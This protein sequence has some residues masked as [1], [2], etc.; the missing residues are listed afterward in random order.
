M[1][2]KIL[3]R[4]AAL[5]FVFVVIAAFVA[6][7]ISGSEAAVSAACGGLCVAIPNSLVVFTLVV[8][9]SSGRSGAMT[10]LVCEFLKMACTC[11]LFVLVAKLYPELVWPAMI[12][13]VIAAVCS[14][15]ALI[16]V[17]H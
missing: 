16:F 10:V 12:F 6:W 8:G 3:V 17:K 7:L 4:V 15:F 9:Q 5:Q 11:M 14:Q 1:N 13:G 2:Q